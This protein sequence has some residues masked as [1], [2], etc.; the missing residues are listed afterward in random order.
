M[1]SMCIDKGFQVIRF[2]KINNYIF[3]N[4]KFTIHS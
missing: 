2:F 3:M 4:V 1:H